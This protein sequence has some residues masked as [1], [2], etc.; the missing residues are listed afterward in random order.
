MAIDPS[1]CV[2]GGGFSQLAH[3]ETLFGEILGQ[4]GTRLPSDRRYE[5]R[6]ITPTEGITIPKSLYDECVELAG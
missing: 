6:K 3:A 5:S 2:S 4:E 1:K